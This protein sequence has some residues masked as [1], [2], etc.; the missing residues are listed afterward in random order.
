MTTDIPRNHESWI[1]HAN[2]LELY[3]GGRVDYGWIR[4]DKA[5]RKC[6]IQIFIKCNSSKNGVV[7]E[8]EDWTKE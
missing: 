4:I 5:G 1:I 6:I 8:T 3:A 2:L 7:D